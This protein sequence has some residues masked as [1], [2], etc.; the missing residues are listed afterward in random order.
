MK[1]LFKYPTCGYAI[2]TLKNPALASQGIH[3]KL[4]LHSVLNSG[5]IK[6]TIG[7]LLKLRMAA[8]TDLGSWVATST[9][10]VILCSKLF[11]RRDVSGEQGSICSQE[12]STFFPET[13]ATSSTS[14]TEGNNVTFLGALLPMPFS[15]GSRL[16]DLDAGCPL[17]S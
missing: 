12:Y 10:L 4:R 14:L 2:A 13:K 8:K 6:K 15:R 16:E 1:C 9:T 17:E 11:W 3:G 7:E 5:L